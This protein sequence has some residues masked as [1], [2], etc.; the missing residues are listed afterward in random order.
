MSGKRKFASKID[1][2]KIFCH[3]LCGAASPQ[4]LV[5]GVSHWEW[6]LIRLLVGERI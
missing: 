2:R 5:A 1:N 4:E 3:V 6:K